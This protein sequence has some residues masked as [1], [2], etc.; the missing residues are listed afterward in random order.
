MLIEDFVDLAR[1]DV[2]AA[3]NDHVGFAIYDEEVTILVA[4]ANVSGMKPTV[5]KSDRRSFWI[6]VIAFQDILAA[7]NNLTQLAVRNLPVVIVKDSHFISDRQTART[8]TSALIWRI[9]S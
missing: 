9:E 4:I 3:A 2:F 6:L 7:Q 1:V 5:A 8:G